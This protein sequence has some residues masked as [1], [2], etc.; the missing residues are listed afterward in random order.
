MLLSSILSL[1]RKIT[2]KFPEGYNPIPVNP[3]K[4]NLLV[5]KKHLF[6]VNLM[7]KLKKK[8][9]LKWY[10]KPEELNY[11]RKTRKMLSEV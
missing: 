4:N 11:Q 7:K 9:L 2:H 10:R 8:L 3:V 1:D 5:L 6:L